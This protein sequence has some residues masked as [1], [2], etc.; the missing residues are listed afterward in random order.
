MDVFTR[1]I[2]GFSVEPAEIDGVCVCR[3]FN[4]AIAGIG[5]PRYLSSDHDPLFTFDRWLAN[6]RVLDIKEIKSV[7]YVPLSHPFIERL[8][9]TIR[10]E[11]LDH[12]LF[13][14]RFDL[15]RNWTTSRPTTANA[16]STVL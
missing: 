11:Y 10:R 12:V 4:K 15:Q 5:L 3:M 9:G 2:I 16:A 1:R 6:L 13:W 8:I 14:N 7:P